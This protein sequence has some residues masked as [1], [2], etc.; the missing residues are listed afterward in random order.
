MPH[1]IIAYDVSTDA[2]QDEEYKNL[3][4]ALTKM[5]AQRVQE[6]VFIVNDRPSAEQIA[7]ALWDTIKHKPSNRVFV[8]EINNNTS[9]SFPLNPEEMNS[10][11]GDALEQLPELRQ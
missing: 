6:S 2:A 11:F 1:Y 8:S 7:A 3:K 10:F 9:Y 5:S 4:D